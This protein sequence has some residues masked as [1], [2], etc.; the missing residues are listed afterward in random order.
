[1]GRRSRKRSKR[2]FPVAILVALH[3]TEAVFWRVYSEKIK[4]DTKVGRGRKRKNQDE[5]QLYHFHQEI[6]D[7]LREIIK[8]GIRSIVLVN[9]PKT[10]YCE[11]FQEHIKKHH[12]WLLRRGPQQAIFAYLE[13]KAANIDQ[14]LWLVQQEEFQ[15]AVERASNAES[16]MIMK[17]LE[18]I[19]N[20]SGDF[21]I[22]AYSMKE[23]EKIV[24]HKWK[25]HEKKPD[26]ILITDE[27][28]ENHRQKNRI[29][30]ILQIAK[31]KNI[32]TKIVYEESDAGS[33]L[34]QLG[35]MVCYR[36]N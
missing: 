16:Y 25:P 21:G 36:K 15:E 20:R 13:G 6:V 10:E 17:N 19:L 28:L 22:V 11:E 5:K 18:E 33:R 31:N 23:I 24:E 7:R 26:Y 2:G 3:E 8:E 14:L 12:R 4:K 35:G 1:M 34:D 32:K 9:P 27:F 30:R 29:Y